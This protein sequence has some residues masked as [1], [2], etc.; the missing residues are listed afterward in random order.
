MSTSE[1][2]A[3]ALV[4]RIAARESW[5]DHYGK[6]WE[7]E[8]AEIVA[9]LDATRSGENQA[10]L[11]EARAREVLATVIRALGDSAQSADGILQGRDHAVWASVALRAM[12]ALAIETRAQPSSEGTGNLPPRPINMQDVRLVAGEGKLKP[13]HV[14]A[15]CNAEIL[16]RWRHAPA[17][18]SSDAQVKA[19][20]LAAAVLDAQAGDGMGTDVNGET[21]WI[22]MLCV[23]LTE[24]FGLNEDIPLSA[25]VRQALSTSDSSGPAGE[26]ER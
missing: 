7:D 10:D 17:Q 19:L 18:P 24:A 26:E 21:V 3:I 2:R 1:T 23:M 5:Q 16:R 4:R 14:L 9:A 20:T 22:D 12:L 6:R 13:E 15:A 11:S 8:A 25:A